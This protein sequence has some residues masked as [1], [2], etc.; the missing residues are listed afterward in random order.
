M[1]IEQIDIDTDD[2]EILLSED[3]SESDRLMQRNKCGVLHR[4]DVLSSIFNLKNQVL[5]DAQ[6]T[7]IHTSAIIHN[8][9]RLYHHSLL[10]MLWNIILLNSFRSKILWFLDAEIC[11]GVK[12][13]ERKFPEEW[14]FAKETS[15]QSTSEYWKVVIAIWCDAS[16]N[17]NRR[18]LVN[19]SFW[20]K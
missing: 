17:W 18:A 15:G 20:G 2:L 1:S 19:R 10:C 6:Y 11:D 8:H 5:I 13:M 9:W 16:F 4:R 3:V 7:F 12:S 14:L